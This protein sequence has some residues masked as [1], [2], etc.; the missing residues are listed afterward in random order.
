MK[1]LIVSGL[2]S[3]LVI[4]IVWI[5]INL[6]VGAALP[7]NLMDLGGMRPM[8]DPLMAL[9]FLHP[10]VLGFAMSYL[11]PYV[12][13]EGK[14]DVQKGLCFGGLMFLVV[15]IPSAY[16]VYTSMDYPIAF[17]IEQLLGGALYMIAGGVTIA[18]L[19]SKK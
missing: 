19:R 6:V 15:T 3:G 2:L 18:K 10:W 5:V 7:Y 14:T 9:S 11:F 1:N 8:E 4:A 12:R 16:M 13:P 17:N